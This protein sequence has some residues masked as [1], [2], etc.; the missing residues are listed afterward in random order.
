MYHCIVNPAAGRGGAERN[1]PAVEALMHEMGADVAV[2]ITD[3]RHGAFSF[4]AAARE[5]A[6]EG[7]IVIGGDG[8]L[9]EAVS[10][11]LSEHDKCD[12]PVGLIACGSGNDWQRTMGVK[13]C[14]DA[15]KHKKI[16]SIDAIKV[17]RQ[18]CIN[19]SNIGLDAIIVRN[20]NPLKKIF[21]TKS[22]IISAVVSI[23]RH[24]NIRLKFKIDGKEHDGRFTLVAVCNGQYYGGGMR[25]TP[26]AE[27]D[28]GQI[29]LCLVSEMSRLRALTLFP[30]VLLEKH[31]NIKEI[32]YINCENVIIKTDGSQTLCIDG[33]LYEVSEDINYKILPGALKIFG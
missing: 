28:D 3:N 1:V 30:L 32:R 25:M 13:N 17:N 22:Y 7:I 16:R 12:I 24:Q 27:P 29:T 18:A 15:V 19:I 21:G 31:T 5:A 10:G 9:Q 33:N 8:T 14:L 6:S 4:A 20:A 26:S 2:N 11:L 23:F